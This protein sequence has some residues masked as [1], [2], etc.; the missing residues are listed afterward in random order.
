M[1]FK[2]FKVHKVHSTKGLVSTKVTHTVREKSSHLR[3]LNC[4]KIKWNIVVFLVQQIN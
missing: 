3:S 2:D 4:L 1:N